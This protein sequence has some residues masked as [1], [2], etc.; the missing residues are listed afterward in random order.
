MLNTSVG[1]LGY[2]VAEWPWSLEAVSHFGVASAVLVMS[3]Q[4]NVIEHFVVMTWCRRAMLFHITRMAHQT[5]CIL[6]RI[7][8]LQKTAEFLEGLIIAAQAPVLQQTGR[9]PPAA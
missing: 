1:Y 4:V 6:L 2:Q 9:V 5:Y 7:Y 8:T 3:L